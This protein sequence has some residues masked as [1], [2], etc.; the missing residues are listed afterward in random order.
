MLYNIKSVN[1]WSLRLFY[2]QIDSAYEVSV[3][4]EGGQFVYQGSTDSKGNDDGRQRIRRKGTQYC[5]LTPIQYIKIINWWMLTQFV[6]TTFSLEI[7][8]CAV[9]QLMPVTKLHDNLFH[10]LHI[11]PGVILMIYH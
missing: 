10:L 5:F 1:D 6:M 4:G 9:L 8:L 2:L 7:I 11:N 3:G